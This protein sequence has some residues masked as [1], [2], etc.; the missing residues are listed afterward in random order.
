[1]L[2]ETTRSIFALTNTG[3]LDG[4]DGTNDGAVKILEVIKSAASA[5]GK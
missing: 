3:Y 4:S 5:A 2:L 1:V